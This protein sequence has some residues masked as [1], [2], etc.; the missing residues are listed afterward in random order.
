ML[1]FSFV[2]EARNDHENRPTRTTIAKLFSLSLFALCLLLSC[3]SPLPQSDAAHAKPEGTGNLSIAVGQ[4]E[5]KT[6][7]LPDIDL[8]PTVYDISGSGPD[9]AYFSQSVTAG[10]T[11][12]S[13]L[14]AGQWTITVT[15][16]N[17]ALQG[18]GQGSGTVTV[19]A[20]QTATVNV[21]VAPL[22]GNGTVS[23][24]VILPAGIADPVISATLSPSTGTPIPLSFVLDAGTGTCVNSTIPSGYYSLCLKLSSGGE[25]LA[26]TVNAV[27]IVS[28][29]TTTGSVDLS[30]VPLTPAS[31][32]PVSVT[33]TQ[34][35]NHPIALTLS[36]GWAALAQG[37]TMSVTATAVPAGGIFSWYLDGT[38]ISPTTDSG[39]TVI[40]PATLA[41][42]SH[43]L[44]CLVF[45]MDGQRAGSASL[46]FVVAAAGTSGEFTFG[47]WLQCPTRTRNGQTNAVNYKNIGINTFVGLYNWP[48]ESWAYSGYN[49]LQAK[50]LQASGQV[51]YA[52]GDA[53]AV[54]WNTA[55]P[56]YASTF[57]GYMLGDEADMN[58]GNPDATLAAASQPTAWLAAGNALIAAD[59]GRQRYANFGKG[60]ALD[61]W[62]GYRASTTQA[63]DFAAYVSPTTVFSSD[64]YG[65]TDPYEALSNHGIWAYGRA[66]DNNRKYAGNRP[67]W[68]FVE[69]SAPFSASLYA[70]GAGN[71]ISRRMLPQY[72]APAVW[73]IV[74]HGGSGVVYF[75]HDFSS[76]AVEDGMLAE[77]GMPAA[78]SAVNAAVASY[79]AVL[80]TPSIAGAT[81]L[82]SGAVP[83]TLLV[84][85]HGGSTYVFAMGDGNAANYLGQA[86]NA[87]ISVPGA[88]AGS[89]VQVLG[90]GRSITLGGSGFS[91]HFNAY[92]LHIY[93]F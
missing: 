80:A 11:E 46:A 56:G 17:A 66:V 85:K 19:L 4:A 27:R 62:N 63:A 36:G 72:I 10:S 79:A 2:R 71:F 22:A 48:S 31:V 1:Q 39:P 92:E 14:A 54:A 38:A 67:V 70:S 20:G 90:E 30:A 89:V 6:L 58:K 68:G 83:V 86:V 69:A 16:K 7:F 13:E 53:A 57:V 47:V 12:V 24:C 42:G 5:G 93:K 25:L 75:A 33:I 40:V 43:Q 55:N 18:I 61:P 52:G 8:T 9:G 77:S 34:S 45:S 41:L 84:K 64:L 60:F 76:G 74:V 91:D 44:D 78:V 50:A 87:Q 81:A 65:I 88:V 51:A 73:E 37:S 49:L 35:M 28:G 59:P 3:A 82:S 29:A 15:E 32:S 26:S 23:L 21:A